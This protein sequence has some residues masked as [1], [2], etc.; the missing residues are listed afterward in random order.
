MKH[1]V[2]QIMDLILNV[3]ADAKKSYGFKD[4]LARIL[5][6]QV[7]FYKMGMTKEFPQEW[8]EFIPAPTEAEKKVEA[9]PIQFKYCECCNCYAAQSKG[10]DYSIYISLK[11]GKY[12]VKLSRGHSIYGTQI[13]PKYATF[14][15]AVIAAQA[16]FDKIP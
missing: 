15:E 9:H 5:E 13:G 3:S 16:D 6:T 12:P 7:S 4:D 2:E 1:T 11:N 10:I 14:E 8:K